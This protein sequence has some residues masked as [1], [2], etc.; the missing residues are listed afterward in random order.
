MSPNNSRDWKYK[1]ERHALGGEC[2]RP[3]T[4]SLKPTVEDS[5]N[6]PWGLNFGKHQPARNQRTAHN[7]IY[8]LCI[9]LWVVQVNFRKGLTLPD[10][11]NGQRIWLHKPPCL[12][13][14]RFPHLS[15]FL[16][17]SIKMIHRSVFLLSDLHACW[18]WDVCLTHHCL[19]QGLAGTQYC[20]LDASKVTC[21]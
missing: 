4:Q 10:I 18:G 9:A 15:L 16:W 8:S 21:I 13:R 6:R 14:T 17:H 20:G 2:N 12:Y 1:H 3:V 7:L 5:E 11:T 19:T